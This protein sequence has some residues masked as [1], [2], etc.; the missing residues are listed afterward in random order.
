MPVSF[1]IKIRIPKWAKGA[2]VDGQPMQ[3]KRMYRISKEWTGGTSFTVKLTDVPHLVSRPQR[4]KTVEYGPL[5]FSL[6]IETECKRY[7]YEKDGVERKFPYC[8]YELYPQ[9]EWR[10]GFAGGEMNIMEQQDDD[11]PLPH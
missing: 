11:I 9:S 10:Y 8:D 6:P 5:V 7:E 2:R 1:E 4:M 3:A